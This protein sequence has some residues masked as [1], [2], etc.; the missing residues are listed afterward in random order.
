MKRIIFSVLHHSLVIYAHLPHVSAG[1]GVVMLH[2][3]VDMQELSLN[4]Q[5]R[6]F[7]EVRDRPYVQ[8]LSGTLYE[9]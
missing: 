8:D 5:G 6:F 1:D 3:A 9:V 2:D 7:A 4:A